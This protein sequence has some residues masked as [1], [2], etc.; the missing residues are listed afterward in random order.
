[1]AA[2]TSGNYGSNRADFGVS[3]HA[4]PV[5]SPG[6]GLLDIINP[7]ISFVWLTCGF[8][9]RLNTSRP[10]PGLLDAG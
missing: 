6:F 1:M 9:G 2:N 10:V 8:R 7:I 3:N 4:E 5:E